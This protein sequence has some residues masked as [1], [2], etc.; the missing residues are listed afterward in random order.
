MLLY[1]V[2]LRSWSLSNVV[3]DDRVTG[4]QSDSVCAALL[5]LTAEGM[6]ATPSPTHQLLAIIRSTH[7]WE[8]GLPRFVE[9]I[10]HVKTAI[11]RGQ[12]PSAQL[13]AAEYF[14][15]SLIDMSRIGEA[16]RPDKCSTRGQ[17]YDTEFQTATKTVSML[18]RL[19]LFLLAYARISD[20]HEASMACTCIQA[21]QRGNTV[22]RVCHKADAFSALRVQFR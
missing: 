2:V 5:K 22:R 17:E 19:T 21:K 20:E 13:V 18:A 14:A 9:R 6:G 10:Q 11:D 3:A 7:G 12:F 4:L 8:V 1:E 15:G 16:A